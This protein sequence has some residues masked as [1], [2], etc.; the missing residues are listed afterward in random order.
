M[1]TSIDTDYLDTIVDWMFDRGVRR[2]RV[3]DIEIELDLDHHL[4]DAPN[5]DADKCI[6]ED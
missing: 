5:G 3:D 4:R 6:G 1:T 2:V